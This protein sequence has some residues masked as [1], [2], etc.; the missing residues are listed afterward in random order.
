[1]RYIGFD[2][3]DGESAVA[4]YENGSS[5]EP[6]I[7]AL[8]GAK[9]VLTAVGMQKGEIVV[10]DAA[11]ASVLSENLDVR[12]KSRFTYDAGSYDSIVRFARGVLRLLTENGLPEPDDRITVG[13]PAGWNSACRA[14]YRDLLARA[15]LRELNL[16]SESRAAFLYA[17]YAKTV[18]LDV[19]VL[20]ES[21]LAIDIGSST[22]DFAYIVDGRETGVGTFGDVRLGGGLLDAEL[23]RRSVEKNRQRGE[24]QA[25]LSE[26]RS[27]KSYCEIEARRLK[28]QFFERL[29]SD[30][31]VS[32]QKRIQVCYD[33][34]QK[35]TMT[36]TA[37][38]MEEIIRAPLE[39]LGGQCFLKALTDALQNAREMTAQ[40][41]PKLLLLTGGASRM[42]FFRDL[43]RE[44]FE[45][46]V[47]VCCPEPE[48][49]IAKGLA[50]AGWIDE[51]LRA[52]RQEIRSEITDA[53]VADIARNALPELLPGV[54]SALSELVLCEA[55]IPIARQWKQGEIDTLDEMNRRISERTERV[56]SSDLCEKALE[57]V[58]TQWVKGLSS[59]L[60]ALV[61]PICDRHHVPR[62]EMRLSFAPSGETGKIS[63]G[64]KDMLGLE[65]V[66]ALVSIL[67]G[68]LAGLLCGGTGTAIIMAGPVG[69]LAGAVMGVAA[70][71]LGWKQAVGALMKAK[72]PRPLRLISVE[73]RLQSE[74]T[75]AALREAVQREIGG[76]D[77]AFC[78][79]V[80]EGFTGSF[81]KYL[82]QIAQAAEIPIE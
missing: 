26:C 56:L 37:D 45:N 50:Y 71:A 47:V 22:L 23:L 58:V 59:R 29:E 57:P 14:R 33:G 77:S 15:G 69:F 16:I 70:A 55:A 42:P 46:A 28:E 4:V 79:E 74:K 5:I 11:Y 31:A 72:L 20:R 27:W 34:V 38:E 63:F 52:F 19:D 54:T 1:M 10:G 53:R 43:C 66:G 44:T 36:L 2:L 75:K 81:Q 62:E 18:A 41:P 82:R 51:N 76:E 13:C 78:K 30:P 35:L 7:L 61:D 12:F 39:E 9:S 40:R 32:V 64:A 6:V 73:K 67:T 17:K 25:V 24:L 49:S 21:A 60:Q 80:V 3:G 65:L 8:G 68:I 48:F